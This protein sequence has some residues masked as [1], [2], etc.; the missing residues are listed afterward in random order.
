M[1]QAKTQWERVKRY[2][3]RFRAINEGTSHGVSS[4]YY[5]DDIYAFFLNCYHLKDWIKNDDTASAAKRSGVE[6]YINSHDC[7]K[8]CA[9]LCNGLKHL[10]LD[11]KPRSGNEPELRGRIFGLNLGQSTISVKQTIEHAGKKID[12]FTLAGDCMKAWEAYMA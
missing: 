7:L 12:A 1:D 8:V 9:D 5:V 6:A 11:R 10:T 2:Y 4:E 3:D